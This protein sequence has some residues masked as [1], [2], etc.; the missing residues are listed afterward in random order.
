MAESSTGTYLI[1][2][3]YQKKFKP[4]IVKEF[5]HEIVRERLS[6]VKY[7]PEKIPE[8]CSSL[9]DC[10]RDKVKSLGIDKYKIIVQVMIGEQRGQGVKMCSRFFWDADT[11][12]Y[13]EDVFMNDS[14][15]CVAAV[16]GCYYY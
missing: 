12:N 10:I 6:G 16:F 8:T 13:A 14:L 2:P 4:A 3:D 15:F 5:V 7:E 1:R 9:A 11:D